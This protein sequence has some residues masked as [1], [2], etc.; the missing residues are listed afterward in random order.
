MTNDLVLL[1]VGQVGR[2]VVAQAGGSR[3]ITGTTRDP[4]KIFQMVES[5]ITPLIMPLPSAEILAPDCCRADVLVSFPPDGETDSV[6][7]PACAG[8]H[9]IIYLSSTGV[10]GRIEGTIDDTTSTDESDETNALRLEAEKIWRQTGAVV[11]RVPGI[12]GSG[13]GL[14]QNLKAG[15]YRLPGSGDRYTSRI[16]VEDLAAIVL[17]VFAAATLERRCYVI[18]D[19]EPC[20]QLEIVTW[21]CD[22]LKLPL[23]GSIPL[24][25]VHRT[26][27][28]NRRVDPSALLTE[29]GITLRYANYREGYRALLKQMTAAQ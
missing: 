4:R 20:T 24:D 1:G 3:K 26:L 21:L 8:A 23:P 6:L 2:A 10:Y 29:L 5:G 22:E 18:G 19:Q 15:T 17:A 16:H 7:A 9:R 14:A 27:R 12:Y 25:Q 11:L 28:G 13:A